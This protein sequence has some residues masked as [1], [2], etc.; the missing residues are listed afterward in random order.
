[1]SACC[2]L[3]AACVLLRFSSRCTVVLSVI[4]GM[5]K[6]YSLKKRGNIRF[7]FSQ[8][9]P[10]GDFFFFRHRDTRRA[11]LPLMRFLL[12]R[13]RRRRRWGQTRVGCRLG[14]WA[15]C[16]REGALIVCLCAPRC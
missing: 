14:A 7:E 1:M 8:Q 5:N 15:A 3:F 16:A 9:P 2:I 13:C 11:G 12:V 4:A 10:S 6:N